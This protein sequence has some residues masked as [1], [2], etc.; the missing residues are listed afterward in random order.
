[1][2]AFITLFIYLYFFQLN[3]ERPIAMC[4]I[5]FHNNYKRIKTFDVKEHFFFFFGKYG[6]VWLS[7]YKIKK[8]T[9]N[10]KR[11]FF[12]YFFR[13]CLFYERCIRFFEMD[14]SSTMKK[15]YSFYFEYFFSLQ[16]VSWIYLKTRSL[17]IIL[18]RRQI[19]WTH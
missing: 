1:M 5:I 9:F 4:V 17:N 16:I 19:D 13:C 7:R 18:E 14:R 2:R 15:T 11:N 8:K 12:I 3:F 10:Y 6:I